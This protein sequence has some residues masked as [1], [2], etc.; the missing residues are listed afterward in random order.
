[1]DCS[2]QHHA[3]SPVNPCERLTA[4][5]ED[6][7][8]KRLTNGKD[9]NSQNRLSQR[10]SI[11]CM[12]QCEN[13]DT[14]SKPDQ[15]AAYSGSQCEL[16]KVFDISSDTNSKEELNELQTSY[17]TKEKWTSE[18]NIDVDHTQRNVAVGLFDLGSQSDDGNE[19]KFSTESQQGNQEANEE[20]I[21][22]IDG[23]ANL[24]EYAPD[25]YGSECLASISA[26]YSLSSIN[27]ACDE[28]EETV[29]EI[30][31]EK[32]DLDDISYRADGQVNLA[33]NED[34]TL[35]YIDGESADSASENSEMNIENADI[36]TDGLNA[37][38][39]YNA[40]LMKRYAPVE[41]SNTVTEVVPVKLKCV[42]SSSKPICS[43][44]P[45]VKDGVN[46][47]S[48][49]QFV[50]SIDHKY[51]PLKTFKPGLEKQ[52][53][54]PK[55]ENVITNSQPLFSS[56]PVSKHV[57]DLEKRD[58]NS[59]MEKGDKS[60]KRN[61]IDDILGLES[62]VV[63]GELVSDFQ[64]DKENH[65]KV[66]EKNR[67]SSR[68]SELRKSNRAKRKEGVNDKKKIKGTRTE[69]F[70]EY[71]GPGLT[72]NLD[73][74]NEN[75]NSKPKDFLKNTDIEMCTL[76]E[77]KGFG[78]TGPL[79]NKALH[80][81]TPAPVKGLSMRDPNVMYSVSDSV[82]TLSTLVKNVSMKNITNRPAGTEGF[83]LNTDGQYP[84]VGKQSTEEANRL[85][86]CK[87][88]SQ[89]LY[90]P[91]S[92]ACLMS[93]KLP[94]STSRQTLDPALLL[95]PSD[96]LSGSSGQITSGTSSALQPDDIY[97][98]V[99]SVR[100]DKSDNCSTD[101]S[102]RSSKSGKPTETSVLQSFGKSMTY[103]I[104]STDL[105]FLNPFANKPLFLCVCR[106]SLLKTLWEKEK[107]LIMSNFSFSHSVFYPFG[108][109]SFIFIKF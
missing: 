38:D 12:C 62:C 57:S 104:T 84:S 78:L 16:H 50:E 70:K 17:N 71:M 80:A 95:P 40:V 31:E 22:N 74:E 8:V 87:T 45:L 56:T 63:H 101:R 30:N 19:R 33:T 53:I 83:I 41:S 1:M 55:E 91:S 18:D 59:G 29:V 9:T 102:D 49:V 23:L 64:N 48:N 88:S 109:L 54:I 47:N 7:V 93:T 11:L 42:G 97:P 34:E 86:H 89:K 5:S 90:Q 21:I 25:V 4:A 15:S 103:S 75:K 107:L 43:S 10:G 13:A 81:S 52:D 24:D 27:A 82:K 92:I 76:T 32:E 99:S 46:E 69:K 77:Y 65:Q 98:S 51:P 68:T 106:T 58:T 79:P 94:S 26:S 72:C 35:R 28:I 61:I 108:E 100:S 3:D 37:D 44:T 60:G 96:T 14:V 73:D 66:S 105:P 67:I 2:N 20:D 6:Q 85:T 36:C 39:G